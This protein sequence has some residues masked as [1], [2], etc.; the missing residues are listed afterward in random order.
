M[1]F[2]NQQIV[3]KIKFNNEKQIKKITYEDN[4]ENRGKALECF[5]LKTNNECSW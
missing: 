2:E 1:N 3:Q 5:I 4:K